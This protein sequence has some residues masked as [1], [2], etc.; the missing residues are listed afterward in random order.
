MMRRQ[1][2]Q[3]AAHDDDF[4]SK[5]IVQLKQRNYLKSTNGGA[6]VT[7]QQ[8]TGE[9]Q[10][11]LH[12]QRILQMQQAGLANMAPANQQ[13]STPAMPTADMMMKAPVGP[14]S[15]PTAPTSAPAP[16]QSQTQKPVP[17]STEAPTA[18]VKQSN[19]NN[20]SG[21]K[22]PNRAAP[23]NP[24]PATAQ[25][26]LKR[27]L[28]EMNATPEMS[29]ANATPMQ[30][31]AN[32]PV[33]QSMGIPQITP[34]Q[35]ASMSDGDK[36]KYRQQVTIATL[37]MI[38]QEAARELPASMPDIPMSPEEKQA[39]AAEIRDLFGK[40]EK[41]KPMLL[42]LSLPT[43]DGKQR[44]KEY[45]THVSSAYYLYH[46]NIPTNWFSSGCV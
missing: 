7:P 5:Q 1:N 9:Q 41:C 8:M 4:V 16:P 28:S 27:P 22:A 13:M 20:H 23:P 30:R 14:N 18:G 36:L 24:S 34:E 15:Q 42:R 31:P 2:P 12:Q 10:L 46:T 11:Q 6:P 39:V 3:L 29:S 40:V 17:P 26:S 21:G 33:P 37:K 45:Y 35:Y 25:K 38:A 43:P 19:G 32:Q 44:A